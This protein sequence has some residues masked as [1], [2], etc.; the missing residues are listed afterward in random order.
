MGE[1]LAP[2]ARW[3]ARRHRGALRHVP[4]RYHQGAAAT[5]FTR[6]SRGIQTHAQAHGG[7]QSIVRISRTIYAQHGLRGFFFGTWCL[8]R[9]LL[10]WLMCDWLA[11]LPALVSGAAP[12]HALFF[13]AYEC[14]RSV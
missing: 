11:G 12:A 5:V 9:V 4:A 3:L 10:P 2:H 6:L 13:G 7:G 14:V 1:P 8:R